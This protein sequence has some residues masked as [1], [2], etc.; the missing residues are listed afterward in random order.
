[1]PSAALP[2]WLDFPPPSPSVPFVCNGSAGGDLSDLTTPT[3]WDHQGLRPPPPLPS[4]PDSN[5]HRRLPQLGNVPGGP[6]VMGNSSSDLPDLQ[7]LDG[8]LATAPPSS[9]LET[10]DEGVGG[11]TDTYFK[12]YG[13]EGLHSCILI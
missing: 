12:L 5:A 2:G 8:L 3:V 10:P 13:G 7:G 9:A 11:T 4:L 1:M 6:L